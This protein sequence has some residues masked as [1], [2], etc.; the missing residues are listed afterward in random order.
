MRPRI[1]GVLPGILAVVA[2][3]G[4]LS[5][6]AVYGHGLIVYGSARGR[7]IEGWAYFSGGGKA[8]NATVRVL[9]PQ[10]ERLGR[11]TTDEGGRFQFRAAR[12]C[13]HTLVL[14]T[15]GGHRAEYTVKAEELPATLPGAKQP[16]SPEPGAP[17][18]EKP[19][20]EPGAARR[21]ESSSLRPEEMRRIVED[22]VAREV[23]PLRGELHRY[24]QSVQFRDVLGGIGYICGMMAVIV[25]FKRLRRTDATARGEARAEPGHREEK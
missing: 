4:F 2:C 20:P 11:V 18:V 1:S 13:D 16:E 15:E 19:A 14:E 23:E 17:E 9:G 3:V 24:R 5:G 8:K 25:Y 12:R 21:G 7:T 6:P 10:G 22:V